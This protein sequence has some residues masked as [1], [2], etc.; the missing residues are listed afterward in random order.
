M[1]R[2]ALVG[3]GIAIGLGWML[4]IFFGIYSSAT[5]STYS[6]SDWVGSLLITAVLWGLPGAF[7]GTILGF[8]ASLMW[9]DGRL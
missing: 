9:R 1:V 5:G 7:F 2:G 3:I 8:F 4:T 6:V